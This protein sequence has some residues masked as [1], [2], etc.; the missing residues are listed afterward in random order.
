MKTQNA[1]PLATWLLKLFCSG[2]EHESVV[3]DLMEQ[4]QARGRAWY[5]RQ[6]LDIVVLAL[7]CKATRRPLITS[8][9]IPVGAIF[10]GILVV[11]ALGAI[12]VS[13]VWPIGVIAIFGGLLVGFLKFERGPKPGDLAQSP[14]PRVARIDSSK[15]AIGG[16]LGAGILI[17]ILFTAA[18]HDLPE[19]RRWAMPGLIGGLAVAVGLQ[20]WKRLHPRNIE[21][22]WLSIKSK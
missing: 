8:H 20:V 7:Y 11:I 19:L 16:G 18:L 3:G 1:P 14:A 13:D 10:A 5:W 15:I 22:H 17:L 6:V 2:P 21:K 4:S 12:L 9:R